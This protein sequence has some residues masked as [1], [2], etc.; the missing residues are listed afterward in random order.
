MVTQMT[1]LRGGCV[2]GAVEIVVADAFRYAG[3]CHCSRCRRRTGSAFSAFAGIGSDQLQ[4]VAGAEQLLKVG[5]DQACAFFC[6]R[7][8]C[9]LYHLFAARSLVHVQLGVLRD[10]P[11]KKPD[12][13]IFVGSKAPWF[14]IT[15]ALPQWPE[16]PES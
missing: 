2:C 14:E 4:V 3:Y 10:A 7:C 12:Q 13:H 9:P 5:D 11:S 6:S 15:D 1:K 8:H 16:L